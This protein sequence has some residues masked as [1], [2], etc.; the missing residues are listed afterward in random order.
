MYRYVVLVLGMVLAGSGWAS[1]EEAGGTHLDL[2]AHWVGYAALAIFCLAYILVILEETLHLRKSKPVLL[3]AGLI[4]II[5]ALAYNSNGLPHEVEAGIRHNFLE[6]GE[7][8]FFLLVAMTYIN[9]M[10][11]RG[12]FDE[13]R[14]WLVRK[15]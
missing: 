3:A 7:L 8:F 10:L 11:E 1:T 4:W 15:G 12:V 5:I 6:Y 9:A 13:L 2:T 14:N